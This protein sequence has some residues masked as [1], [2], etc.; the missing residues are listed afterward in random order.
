MALFSVTPLVLWFSIPTSY[1]SFWKPV[2]LPKMRPASAAVLPWYI[3][4]SEP[5]IASIGGQHLVP[6][7][8]FMDSDQL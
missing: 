2:V 4:R 6:P 7:A 5:Q 3:C 1:N 8:S